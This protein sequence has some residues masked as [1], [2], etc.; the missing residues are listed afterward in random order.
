MLTE[1]EYFVAGK[2]RIRYCLF[3]V[4]NFAEKP[5][6]QFFFDPLNSSLA[7]QKNER[8]V[9]QINYATSI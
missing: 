2:L 1:K 9:T 6:Y 3:V 7:F 4:K 8:V 5:H